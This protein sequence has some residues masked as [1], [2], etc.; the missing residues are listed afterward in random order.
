MTQNKPSSFRNELQNDS[1]GLCFKDGCRLVQLSD[2]AMFLN[3]SQRMG[4]CLNDLVRF[5]SSEVYTLRDSSD[6]S[7]ANVEIQAG[8]LIQIS[9]PANEAVAEQY[10]PHL[11]LFL[12][13]RG[14][15][16]SDISARL[17]FIEF[18]E[19]TFPKLEDCTE[20]FI[21]WS[22]KNSSPTVL[23]FQKHPTILEFLNV[24]ARHGG[25]AKNSTRKS[26]AD[27]FTPQPPA[28]CLSASTKCGAVV[29]YPK[30]PTAL[31]HLT[32]Y[33]AIDAAARDDA[34]RTAIIDIAAVATRE[35]ECVFDLSAE[36]RILTTDTFV[37]LLKR[38]GTQEHY[39]HAR[40]IAYS[41][42]AVALDGKVAPKLVQRL[43]TDF[44]VI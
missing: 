28:W 32:R 44:L 41:E 6:R 4:N 36:N 35:S 24:F 7:V 20:A 34:F 22:K 19:H 30:F 26:V 18:G 14:I 27:L 3:E 10:H 9:G 12:E 5:A 38:T 13:K 29:Q 1:S 33:G 43:K 21:A 42:K 40:S 11:R 16:S 2:T 31:L 17:G 37:D 39:K 25:A 8:L 23:P 15:P